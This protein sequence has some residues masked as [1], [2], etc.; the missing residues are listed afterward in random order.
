[1]KKA[2]WK[3]KKIT[4]QETKTNWNINPG[5]PTDKQEKQV[6]HNMALEVEVTYN[7]QILKDQALSP[8]PRSPTVPQETRLISNLKK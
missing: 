5:L 3:I 6:I 7:G 1:M 8:R 4:K 2:E